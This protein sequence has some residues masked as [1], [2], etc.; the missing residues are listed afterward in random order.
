VIGVPQPLNGGHWTHYIEGRMSTTWSIGSVCCGSCAKTTCWLCSR[1]RSWWR[2]QST[3]VSI[4]RFQCTV[5][6]NDDWKTPYSSRMVDFDS[7]LLY[8]AL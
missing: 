4:F 3:R 1:G 5:G 6:E 7:H 8:C 2:V